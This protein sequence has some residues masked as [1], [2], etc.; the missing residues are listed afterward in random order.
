MKDKLHR[1]GIINSA[2]CVLCGSHD[3]DINCLFF[4]C[5]FSSYIWKEILERFELDYGGQPWMRYIEINAREWKRN[6]L[7]HVMGKLRLGAT[8][9]IIQRERNNRI[10]SRGMQSKECIKENIRRLV[11]D[12][13]TQLT[14][15][16][17]SW[18]NG[19]IARKQD[20]PMCI[21]KQALQHA[22]EHV[23]DVVQ[24]E[25]F[26]SIKGSIFQLLCLEPCWRLVSGNLVNPDL[27]LLLIS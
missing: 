25:V 20:L 10:F 6:K 23:Q 11:G 2:T 26:F 8:T 4:Q 7:K 18:S 3:E 16:Q 5:N 24:E 1:I 17:P 27:L 14:N 9:Y 13:R 12:K 15:A 19:R 21:F 22:Q